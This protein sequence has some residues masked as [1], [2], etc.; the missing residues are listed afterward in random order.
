MDRYIGLDVHAQSCTLCTVGPSGR[1]LKSEVVETN[2]QA[3]V[4]YLKTIPRPRHLCL[5][6]G[7]QSAWLHEILSPH[8]GELL[9]V[10]LTES[11]G[12]KSDAK[13]A[14]AL[15][16]NCGSARSIRPFSRP[17]VNSRNSALWPRDTTQSQWT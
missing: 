4:Q 7:T 2:G 9:V 13:D 14:L 12:A 17:R 8:V 16:Q 1:K 5:E 6:E 15:A 3:L 10:G 11:R